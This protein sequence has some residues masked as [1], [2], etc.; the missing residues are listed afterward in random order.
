M[1][2]FAERLQDALDKHPERPTQ[3]VLARAAGVKSSS[4]AD[5]FSGNTG[6]A[7][8]QQRATCPATDGSMPA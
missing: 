5:W 3:A 2:T 6:A 1:D 4:M 7:N 8:V